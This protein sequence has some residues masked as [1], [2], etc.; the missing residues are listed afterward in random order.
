MKPE[1]LTLD[2]YNATVS[3][4]HDQKDAAAAI[5][6]GSFVEHHLGN[7]LQHFMVQ[8]EK[9]LKTLFGP[10]GPISSFSQR[11]QIAFALGHIDEVCRQDLDMIRT[12]R[13]YFAHAPTATNFQDGK[14]LKA[15]E[16]ISFSKMPAWKADGPEPLRD[17]R[18]IYL[19]TIS[20]FVGGSI[21]NMAKIEPGP[22]NQ[23]SDPEE[24]TETT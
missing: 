7:Y 22:L 18:L 8:D 4:F 23:R 20:N 1:K 24:N 2:D 14:V 21:H 3:Y 17:P 10:T 9:F 12:I 16:K 5:V 15:I 11:I 19:W 6:A 13:N